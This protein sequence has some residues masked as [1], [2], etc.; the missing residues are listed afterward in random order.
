[1]QKKSWNYT[2]TL[3]SFVT[4]IAVGSALPVRAETINSTTANT[5]TSTSDLEIETASTQIAQSFQPGR[6][7]RSGSSYI[8]VGGNLGLT[9]NTRVGEGSFAVF[10]KVG[11]TRNLS[12]RPAALVG[13]NTVF[14][15]PLTIDFPQ[16]N[17]EVTQLSVA[18]YIGGGV[19]IS[20]G[21]DSTV[22]A[23]ITGGV[24]VPLSS[25][26]TAT[27][28]VN[29]SFIDETDVG[30]LLGIGYNF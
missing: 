27:G 7:T 24:D 11:L 14:L 1:M 9:G 6:A 21:R 26:I 12:A 4:I 30:I 22:G 10:S 28:G 16:E 2:H 20:T 19:A 15:V 3:L 25:Q 8:G 17:L 5:P 13:D 23:L 18:P 29:V